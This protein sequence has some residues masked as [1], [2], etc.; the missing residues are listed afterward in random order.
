MCVVQYTLVE[1]EIDAQ[2]IFPPCLHLRHSVV[3]KDISVVGVFSMIFIQKIEIVPLAKNILSSSDYC[4]RYIVVAAIED[5][6]LRDSE[7]L[8]YPDPRPAQA[9]EDSRN[10]S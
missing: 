4:A 3:K 9:P 7:L 8:H 6:F 1:A 10:S 5:D 2:P